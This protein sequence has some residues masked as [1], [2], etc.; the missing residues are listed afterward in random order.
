MSIRLIEG[1]RVVQFV[2]LHRNPPHAVVRERGRVI[3]RVLDRQQVAGIVVGEPRNAAFGIGD[4]GDLAVERVGIRRHRRGERP[5][6]VRVFLGDRG[7]AVQRVESVRGFVPSVVGDA[8]A[9]PEVVVAERGF[10]AE[11]IGDLVEQ[12]ASAVGVR[13]FGRGQRSR[14]VRIGG[15]ELG[16]SLQVVVLVRRFLGARSGKQFP[17]DSQLDDGRLSN[18]L[19]QALPLIHF[20]IW[21][22]SHLS[23]KS[24]AGRKAISPRIIFGQHATSELN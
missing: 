11:W 16:D 3:D 24:S 19:L 5:R 9:S 6:P 18:I 1:P 4:R 12:P 17:P 13:G 21:T 7:H 22:T 10:P 8:G 15:R 14:A 23:K 20:H 2:G